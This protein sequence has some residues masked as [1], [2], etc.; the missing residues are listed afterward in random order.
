[1]VDLITRLLLQQISFILTIQLKSS[2]YCV[3]IGKLS[4]TSFFASSAYDGKPFLFM[5]QYQFRST[6]QVNV[7]DLL[8]CQPI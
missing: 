6:M 7:L 1:M 2:V 8:R 5:K 3:I 4:F